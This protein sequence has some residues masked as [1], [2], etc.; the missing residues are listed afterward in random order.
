MIAT[1]HREGGTFYFYMVIQFYFTFM[2]GFPGGLQFPAY[3]DTKSKLT[4]FQ[5]FHIP[6][7]NPALSSFFVFWE[8]E[9]FWW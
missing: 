1:T 8:G 3:L 2:S 5:C 4:T 7:L 6:Q 9:G